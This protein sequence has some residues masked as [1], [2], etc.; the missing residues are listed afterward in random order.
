MLLNLEYFY[1]IVVVMDRVYCL[2]SNVMKMVYESFKH[3]L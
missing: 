2:S 3:I 1:L